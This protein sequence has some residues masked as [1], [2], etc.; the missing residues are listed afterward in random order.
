MVFNKDEI[1]LHYE[2]CGEGPAV[3]LLHGWGCNLSI[4]ASLAG[5]LSKKYKVY[6]IDLPGFGESSEP[7]TVWGTED[8]V[9]LLESFV[10]EEGIIAPS[11]IGH[12]FGGRLSI[13]FSSRNKVEKVALIDSAGIV[14]KRT[15]KYYVKVY[16]YKFFRVL[17]T[18]FLS[19]EKSQKVLDRYRKKVGSSDYNNASSTMRAIL[20]K[21]V[22]E[23]L[24][25]VM[26]LIS[27]PVLLFWGT[28]DTATPLSDAKEMEGLIPDAGLVTAAGAGHY[29]FLENPNL[30]NAVISSFFKIER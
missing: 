19:K 22:N 12:S 13:L 6:S 24:R 15:F 28:A 8:Y 7:D 18:F 26:P 25:P 30:F 27:A 20:S 9:N 29:S 21:V 1:R 5:L 3:L 11:L 23:D 14:P 17:C 2:C 16:S 10:K 4:F